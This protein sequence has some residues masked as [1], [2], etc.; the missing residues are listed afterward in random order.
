[1]TR[2]GRVGYLEGMGCR[3]LET[4]GESVPVPV[5]VICAL[6]ILENARLMAWAPVATRAVMRPSKDRIRINFFIGV[7]S[8]LFWDPRRAIADPALKNASVMP[9]QAFLAPFPVLNLK[10]PIQPAQCQGG[11]RLGDGHGRGANWHDS[12][13]FKH[14]AAA[15]AGAAVR[16]EDTDGVG[17]H[18]HPSFRQ[19]LR[20]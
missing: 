11:A 20:S 8:F 18:R 3:R 19:G 14:K 15:I 1:M 9:D 5:N 4:N 7:L 13:V 2:R 6:S 10:A 12:A 17:I 16:A